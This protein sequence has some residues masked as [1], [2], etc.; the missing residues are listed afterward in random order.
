M[1]ESKRK[2]APDIQVSDDPFVDQRAETVQQLDASDPEHVHSYVLG[3]SDREDLSR[4]GLEVVEGK[5]GKPLRHGMDIVVRQSKERFEK[6]RRLEEER[7]AVVADK[8]IGKEHSRK[9]PQAKKP[10]PKD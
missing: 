6:R 9:T 1:T 3:T 4:R 8:I 10:K 2:T 5:D 7:S